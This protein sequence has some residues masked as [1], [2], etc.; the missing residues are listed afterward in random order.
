[1]KIVIQSFSKIVNDSF[2]FHRSFWNMIPL[3]LKEGT[4]HVVEATGNLLWMI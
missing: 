2:L 4:T 1:M 3:N